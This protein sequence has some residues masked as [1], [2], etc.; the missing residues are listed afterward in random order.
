MNYARIIYAKDNSSS[1]YTDYY[2]DAEENL[3]STIINMTKLGVKKPS[4][5]DGK[6]DFLELLCVAGMTDSS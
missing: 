1:E 5:G 6:V 2:H 4:A 3:K